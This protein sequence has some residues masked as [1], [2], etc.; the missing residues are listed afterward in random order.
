MPNRKTR[1]VVA[2]RTETATGVSPA[3]EAG[4]ARSL[5]L[6]VSITAAS[7]TSPTFVLSVAW[8]NDDGNTWFAADPAD[9]F[10]SRSTAGGWVKTF[11]PKGLHYRVTWTIGGTTPSFTF[12]VQETKR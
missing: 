10:T 9:A 12:S 1:T 11:T 7:G 6:A 5:D 8:S 4:G 2:S 3:I